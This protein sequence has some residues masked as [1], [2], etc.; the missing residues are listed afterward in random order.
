MK[1]IAVFIASISLISNVIV[2][3][4]EKSALT[5]AVN[6]VYDH[7]VEIQTE[8]VKD[9]MKGVS[10]NAGAIA[11]AVRGDDKKALP[12]EVAKEADDLAKTK[13]VSSAREAFK[14]LSKS[15]IKYL[16]DQKV[17]SDSFTEV[18]CPM[19]DASWLQTDTEVHNP[20]L[21]KSMPNC[22]EIKHTY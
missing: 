1:K 3:A 11:K 17:H 18:Y 5:P 21:G 15:L 10:E 19:A 9:S 8:L 6:S 14:P 2:R 4:G 16:A 12:P 7:Y 20:Y 22:G 13:D